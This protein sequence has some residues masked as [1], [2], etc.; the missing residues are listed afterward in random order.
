VEYRKFLSDR[1]SLF[2]VSATREAIKLLEK[3]KLPKLVRFAAGNPGPEIYPYET[4]AEIAKEVVMQYKA[5]VLLYGSTKGEKGFIESL[6]SFMYQRGIN[7]RSD[8]DIIVVTGSQQA[9]YLISTLLVNPGDYIALENPTYLAAINAF[10]TANPNMIGVPVD[11]KG[12]KVEIL[13][14]ELR[15]LKNSGKGLKYVYTIPTA[16]NPTGIS[17]TLDRKKYLLELASKYDFLVVEDDPYSYFTYED[18]DTTSLKSLDSEGRVIYISTMSK[19]FAPALR[20]GWVLANSVLVSQ[21]ERIKAVIDLHTPLI[22]QCMSKI[23]IERGLVHEVVRKAKELYKVKRDAMLKALEENIPGGK[24]VKPIG[25][26]FVMVWLPEK[27]NTE[28][29]LPDALRAGVQYVPG[30]QFFVDD[31]GTNTLRLNFSYPPLEDIP[32]GIEVLGKLIKDKLKN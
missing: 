2:R 6:K 22:S 15:K 10:K 28:A 25:G 3:L 17:T 20:V 5:S 31:S 26:L 7:V 12:M 13:E 18:T 16:S 8:D 14:E 27:I 24:W 29:L 30:R 19:I 9:L 32:Y 4:I 21:L 23:A 11:E 1:L